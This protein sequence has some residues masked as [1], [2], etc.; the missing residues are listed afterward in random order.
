[1]RAVVERR[2]SRLASRLASP[3]LAPRCVTYPVH[4]VARHPLPLHASHCAGLAAQPATSFLAHD[5]EPQKLQLA[6]FPEHEAMVIVAW[7]G[8]VGGVELE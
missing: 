3:R 2:D 7:C 8:W 1:M 4:S 5:D 6:G